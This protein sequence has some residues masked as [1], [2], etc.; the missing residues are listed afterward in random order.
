MER[1][2][3][4][5]WHLGGAHWRKLGWITYESR[6]AVVDILLAAELEEE[7]DLPKAG[8]PNPGLQEPD[9]VSV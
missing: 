2:P 3:D 9:G 1:Y 7:K 4:G 8:R 5:G 6:K